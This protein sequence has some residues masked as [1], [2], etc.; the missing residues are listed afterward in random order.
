MTDVAHSQPNGADLIGQ[1]KKVWIDQ[2]L[3]TG[4][5]LCAEIVPELFQ[6]GTHG[7]AYVK[8][9]AGHLMDEPG[10]ARSLANIPEGKQGLALEAAQDCPGECIFITDESGNNLGLELFD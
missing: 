4:D 10:G 9:E 2:D 3:C 7:L 5:G 6:M 8:D 1:V